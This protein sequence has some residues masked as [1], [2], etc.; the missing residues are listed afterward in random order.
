[1]YR[2]KAVHIADKMLPAFK[3]PTGIPH[4]LINVYTGVSNRV[5]IIIEPPILFKF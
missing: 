5:V 4:A 3:T 1:M 2:D